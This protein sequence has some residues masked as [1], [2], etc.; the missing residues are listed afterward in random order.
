M[1]A[2]GEDR[3]EGGVAMW[4]PGSDVNIL[5]LYCISVSVLA[6]MMYCS[7]ARYYHW[8]KWVKGT[9]DLLFLTTACEGT[10]SQYKKFN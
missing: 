6:M 9:C 8:G 3:K 2:R 4:D 10:S 1:G 5:C 7:F